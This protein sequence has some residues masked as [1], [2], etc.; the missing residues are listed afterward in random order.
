MHIL[1]TN[2]GSSVIRMLRNF[3]GDEKFKK[4]LNVS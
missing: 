1:E 3:L 2:Q 4:G